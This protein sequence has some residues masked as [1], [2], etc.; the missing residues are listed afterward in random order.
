MIGILVA[1]L[2]AIVVYIL[3]EVATNND[4]VA[5]VGA[6]L[7]LIVGI[8]GGFRGIGGPGVGGGPGVRGGFDR[9]R[10]RP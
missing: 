7:V 6:I 1:V 5:A 4:A 9:F 8:L 2:L 3:L 10:R